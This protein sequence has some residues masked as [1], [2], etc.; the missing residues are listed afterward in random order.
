[1]GRDETKNE[2]STE[3]TELE[4]AELDKVAGGLIGLDGTILRDPIVK[5]SRATTDHSA[6][7]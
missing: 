1:M 2:D 6:L 5:Q 3:P 4:D 7:D